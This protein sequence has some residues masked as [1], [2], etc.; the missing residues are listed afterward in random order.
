MSPSFGPLHV[1]SLFG[2]GFKV[3]T[4]VPDMIYDSRYIAIPDWSSVQGI[5]LNLRA[6]PWAVVMRP[7]FDSGGSGGPC[8][9]Q[10]I[11]IS[12]DSPSRSVRRGLFAEGSARTHTLLDGSLQHATEQ[13]PRACS[14]PTVRLPH[15]SPPPFLWYSA[16]TDLIDTSCSNTQRHD[17]R[18]GIARLHKCYVFGS[19]CGVHTKSHSLD[20]RCKGA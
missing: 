19:R 6:F 9:A 13:P 2:W 20:R 3:W 4:L 1:S 12:H 8:L 10:V 16:L 5:S 11:G 14:F 17:H 7:L 18:E 15:G